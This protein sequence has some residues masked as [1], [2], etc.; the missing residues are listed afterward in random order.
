MHNFHWKIQKFKNPFF[1]ILISFSINFKQFFYR[2]SHLFLRFHTFFRTFFNFFFATALL[3]VHTNLLKRKVSLY[4]SRFSNFACYK[5][6]TSYARTHARMHGR[7]DELLDHNTSSR[8]KGPRAKI[9]YTGMRLNNQLM[10]V[11]DSL[12]K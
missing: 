5:F 10:L 7:T 2:I 11:W 3:L 1:I 9:S 12:D 6:V 8:P 4:L